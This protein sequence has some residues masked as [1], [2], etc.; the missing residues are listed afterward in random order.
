VSPARSG[1]RADEPVHVIGECCEVARQ[2]C[3][4]WPRGAN[5]ADGVRQRDAVP[6]DDR[7]NLSDDRG[8]SRSCS[9]GV[10]ASRPRTVWRP[11]PS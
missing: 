7:T 8:A 6:A 11:R 2:R 9:R 5:Q 10:P 4:R 1:L 3:R